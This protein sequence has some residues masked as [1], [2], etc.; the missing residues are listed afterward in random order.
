M[1]IFFKFSV[2]EGVGKMVFGLFNLFIGVINV[3]W[4]IIFFVIINNLGN[5]EIII[6]DFL[7]SI[8][9][10]RFVLFFFKK[11]FECI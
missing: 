11:E 9:L 3:C 10:N 1:L 6:Y 8:F 7:F 5:F 4:N 2:F